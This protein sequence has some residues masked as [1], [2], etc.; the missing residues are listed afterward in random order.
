[1]YTPIQ[2][3]VIDL[4]KSL[5]GW[6]TDELSLIDIIC[7]KTNSQMQELKNTYK[8]SKIIRI[9]FSVKMLYLI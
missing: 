2:L 8:L 5:E 7:T 6:G 3:E 9:N 4:H 1:M